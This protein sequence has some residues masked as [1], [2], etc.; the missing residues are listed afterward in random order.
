MLQF[1]K[2][3]SD[4]GKMKYPRGLTVHN[5][6]VH[7]AV[8]GNNRISVFLSDG[9]FHQTIGRGQLDGPNDVVMMSYLWLTVIITAYTGL[10]W[11]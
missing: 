2:Y 9:T 7:V 4:D 8:Y 5:G 6:K 10:Y 11:W 1:G 3:G